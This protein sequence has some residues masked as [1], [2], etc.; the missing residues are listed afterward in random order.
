MANA[1]TIKMESNTA[2]RIV[3]VFLDASSPEFLLETRLVT[4]W[5]I[6]R[7]FVISSWDGYV[8]T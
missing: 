7:K 6:F 4:I 2:V 1:P 8:S 5:Y 3:T